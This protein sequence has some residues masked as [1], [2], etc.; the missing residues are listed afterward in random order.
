M[1]PKSIGRVDFEGTFDVF[2]FDEG[3]VESLV[4][5]LA[6]FRNIGLGI[7]FFRFF[8]DGPSCEGFSPA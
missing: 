2:A 4:A 6:A 8:S 5:T 7:W 1:I 3:C